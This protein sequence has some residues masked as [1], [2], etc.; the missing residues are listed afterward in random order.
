MVRGG[1]VGVPPIPHPAGK[2][3]LHP[4]SRHRKRCHTAQLYLS[5]ACAPRLGFSNSQPECSHY[6]TENS[7]PANAPLS[8]KCNTHFLCINLYNKLITSTHHMMLL[9]WTRVV[10]FTKMHFNILYYYNLSLWQLCSKNSLYWPF[11]TFFS[12]QTIFSLF[13][14]TM[15]C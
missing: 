9:A 8:Q 1:D 5:R 4:A 10:Q 12:V 14:N 11:F 13:K 15:F 6:D 7:V 2:N 3:W